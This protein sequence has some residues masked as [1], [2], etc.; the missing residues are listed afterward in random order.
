MREFKL[1]YNEMKK[2]FIKKTD[3]FAQRE[4]F[5][6]LMKQEY[7]FMYYIFCD[8]PNFSEIPFGYGM[9]IYILFIN[10][11]SISFVMIYGHFRI[12]L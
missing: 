10:R 6:F 12:R 7:Y 4:R 9:I 1:I 11:M 5:I 3:T 8:K 2:H